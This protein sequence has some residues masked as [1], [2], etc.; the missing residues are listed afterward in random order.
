[1][2]SFHEVADHSRMVMA[3]GLD[4]PAGKP[5]RQRA[6]H[7]DVDLARTAFA[8]RLDHPDSAVEPGQYGAYLLIELPPRISR[9]QTR[10]EPFDEG[11]PRRSSS[12]RMRRLTADGSTPSA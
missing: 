8:G 4:Q 1:M 12:V 6:D 3:E 5:R 11:P 7:A 2:T 10:T 9:P